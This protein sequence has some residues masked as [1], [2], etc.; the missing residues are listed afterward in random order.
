MDVKVSVV[1]PVYNV[2]KYVEKCLRSI[3]AQTYEKWEAFVVIDGSTDN[4]IEICKKIAEEDSRFCIL[5]KENGGLS[6][7]RNFALPYIAGEYVA[8]VDSD[9]YLEP[10]YLYNLTLNMV[11][12]G[13]DISM[14]GYV[15]EDEE[16]NPIYS[17]DKKSRSYSRE[18]IIK[19]M[20][21]PFNRSW[22]SYVWNKLYSV[23]IIREHNLTFNEELK[24][25]EDILFNYQYLKWVKTG[26]FTTEPYYHYLKRGTSLIHDYTK[27]PVNKYL[28]ST[29]S[30]DLV[31]EDSKKNDKL[32]YD[33]VRIRKC[34]QVATNL[35]MLANMDVKRHPRYIIE[36]RFLKRNLLVFLFCSDVPLSKR[37][38]A[39]LTLVSPKYAYKIW[40]KKI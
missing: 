20:H 22:D 32:Y 30:Y 15:Y 39:L 35:R 33:H 25:F 28:Y 9:D 11:K 34:C 19:E 29:R 2:E 8:F 13:A 26:Y 36:K 24:M 3:M 4:S 31:L 38:G 21:V 6:S 18:D 7:A 10:D 12:N 23:K 16:G 37:L 1:V 5:T 14:C 40:S 17:I 27:D